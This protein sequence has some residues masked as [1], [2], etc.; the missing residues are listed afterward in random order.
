MFYWSTHLPSMAYQVVCIYGLLGYSEHSADA[1]WGHSFSFF[2]ICTYKLGMMS[3]TKGLLL[4]YW[5][6]RMWFSINLLSYW[7]TT[8]LKMFKNC[9][10]RDTYNSFKRR[11]LY[12]E[13]Q[14]FLCAHRRG[15]AILKMVSKSPLSL[16]SYFSS[17]S[18]CLLVCEQGK[19]PLSETSVNLIF[20]S[21]VLF[22]LS[23]LLS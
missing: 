2:W 12:Y 9:L 15:K 6:S 4:A 19:H 20:S 17:H 10:D 11:L 1:S 8:A 5:V 18:V 7:S 14:T 21:L 23:C 13:W 22:L 16:W 3:Q